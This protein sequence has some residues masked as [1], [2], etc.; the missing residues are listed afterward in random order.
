MT[1]PIVK[2]GESTNMKRY[3]MNNCKQKE[4]VVG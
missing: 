1:V 2:I 3:H 4:K